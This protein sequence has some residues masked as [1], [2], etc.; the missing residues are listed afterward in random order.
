MVDIIHLLPENVANQIAAGEVIQRPASAVK[1]LLENAVDSGAN[2]IDLII[3]DAGKGLI[4]VIDNGCG[5]S[6]GDLRRCI[7]RHATSKIHQ[8]ADLFAIRTLGFRG[9]ALASIASIAHLEI[10]SRRYDDITGFSLEVEGS[11]MRHLQE[12]ATPEGTSVAVKNLFYNVPARR[13]FLKSNTAELRHILEEFYRVA[14]VRPG[15]AFSVYHNDRPLHKVIASN[16]LQRITS[17]FGDVLRE[18]LLPVKLDT[19]L[20]KIQGYIGKPENVRKTKGEQYFFANQRFIRHPYLHHAVMNAYQ[21]LIP[22]STFPTYFLFLEVDPASIDV[23]IH[24]TKTEI[25]FQ[26]E[27]MIYGMMRSSVR[28]ALGKSTAMPSLDFDAERSFELPPEMRNQAVKVPQIKIDPDY[29]PFRPSG[30]QIP[31]RER[32]NRERWTEL[33]ST[34]QAQELT[35]PHSP[36]GTTPEPQVKAEAANSVANPDQEKVFQLFNTYIAA[37]LKSGLLLVHQARAHQKILYERFLRSIREAQ[38]YSQQQLFP[39]TIQ[40]SPNEAALLLDL[41]QDPGLPG[42][43]IRD[44]GGGSFIVDGVPADM[45]ISNIQNI[46]E[47]LMESYKEGMEQKRDKDVSAARAMAKSLALQSGEKLLPE[48]MYAIIDDLF[49]C[50]LPEQGLDGK[51]CLKIL[52]EEDLNQRFA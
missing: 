46:L 43:D 41:I 2:R 52:K 50:P 30:K 42:F 19:D 8:A 1:E 13:K 17:L 15:I 32:H 20:L 33:F 3:K 47:S 27:K 4:Q 11:E 16:T 38:R 49:A 39:I 51:A 34:G 24:P 5:M 31:E 18:R 36:T 40:F 10:R 48:E 45:R 25:K 22:D 14:L 26:D 7:L 37:P 44:M 12:T 28:E 35:P 9:E 29:N 21:D 23:N 6:E